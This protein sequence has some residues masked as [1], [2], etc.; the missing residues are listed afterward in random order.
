MLLVLL[1]TVFWDLVTAVVIGVFIANVLTIKGQAEALRKASRRLAGG[2]L[3]ADELSPREQVLLQQAGSSCA[4]LSLRGPL[5]FGASRY[6][7]QLLT[8]SDAYS[9]IVLD[10]SAVSHL[11]VTASLALDAL[12]RDASQQGRKV[13]IAVPEARH[14]ER[15]ARLQIDAEPG[16]LFCSSRLMALEAIQQA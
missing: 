9:T 1:L 7:T 3:H 10:L 16:V 11:G 6:L 14:R 2:E 8:D 13:L 12:C 5:S 15:L 4:L